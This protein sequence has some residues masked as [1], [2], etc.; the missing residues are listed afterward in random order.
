MQTKK[1]YEELLNVHLMIDPSNYKLFH[2][3]E[4]TALFRSSFE[5]ATWERVMVV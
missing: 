1:I 5:T 4:L 3:F 2:K